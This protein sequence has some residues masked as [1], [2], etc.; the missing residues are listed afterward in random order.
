MTESQIK[1]LTEKSAF[2]FNKSEQAS[3]LKYTI[4]RLRNSGNDS[5]G[6]KKQD[7]ITESKAIIEQLHTI[8]PKYLYK[9]MLAGA[10]EILSEINEEI[11]K[12]S[13]LTILS[14]IEKG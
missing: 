8:N 12:T 11:D 1:L 13:L 7:I 6:Y 10:N 9:M 5:D 2:I 14:E 3:L 4:N